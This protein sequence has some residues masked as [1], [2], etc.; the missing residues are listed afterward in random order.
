MSAPTGDDLNQFL[1]ERVN[2]RGETL[3]PVTMS[4]LPYSDQRLTCFIQSI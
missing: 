3:L 4:V 1:N 2:S